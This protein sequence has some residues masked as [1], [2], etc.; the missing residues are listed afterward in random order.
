MNAALIESLRKKIL[1]IYSA[2][3]GNG[4]SE[5]AANLAFSIARKGIRTWVLDANT[6]APAQDFILGFNV[7]GPTFSDFL[8]DPSVKEMPVYPLSRIYSNPHP[9]PL[10]I[11][12][13]ER[14]N[15][16][17]RFALQETLN[18]STDIY[19]R[20]PGAVFDAMAEHR[21]DLL[22][23]DTHPSFE[24]VNEV[25]MGMTEFLL[26]ISR[27][28][29]IDF[30]NLKSLLKDP[31]VQD[32]EQKL[33]VITNVQ[34]DHSRNVS[35]DMENDAIV[36]QLKALHKQFEQ[37]PCMLG[38]TDPPAL[39]AGKT[40]IHKKAFLYSEKLAL[41]QQASQRNG[42]FIDKEPGDSFSMN[43]ERLGER[44]VEMVGEGK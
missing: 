16:K 12:P 20:I 28:N 27:I 18:S 29:P 38:C 1:V 25:W 11:T 2:G 43:I 32:I 14:D 33:I 26:L 8:T 13:S 3:C 7:Q 21:I 41:F 17:T 36:E 39:Q 23:I 31:S 42:M 30:K 40:A 9:L 34:I 5:I 10:F 35:Q 6:F 24:R 4:K 19:S 37:E 22:I 44:V 15:Q